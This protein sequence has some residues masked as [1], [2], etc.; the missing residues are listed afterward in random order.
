[1]SMEEVLSFVERIQKHV[2]KVFD[3]ELPKGR[4]LKKNTDV[5]A[6]RYFIAKETAKFAERL[7]GTEYSACQASG[8]FDGIN[9]LTP[10]SSAILFDGAA[11]VIS[12]S[13][14]RPATKCD[15]SLFR[16]AL[17]KRGVSQDIIDKCIQDATVDLRPAT[18]I[19]ARMR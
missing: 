6:A 9:D 12:A 4:R 17:R 19:M 8:M 7:L 10:G 14:N 15:I 11:I 18:I 16:T 2:S 1:M 13:K 3:T 5:L